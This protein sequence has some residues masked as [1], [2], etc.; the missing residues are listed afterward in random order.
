MLSVQSWGFH[1]AIL[2]GTVSTTDGSSFRVYHSPVRR[3]KTRHYTTLLPRTSNT[4]TGTIRCCWARRPQ[5]RLNVTRRVSLVTARSR[6]ARWRGEIAL[7][8][9][10]RTTPDSG[11]MQVRLRPTGQKAPASEHGRTGQ[12]RRSTYE[13]RRSSA[14]MVHCSGSKTKLCL[15]RKFATADGDKRT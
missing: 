9:R 10:R 8:G 12:S 4:N 1:T 13:S 11:N 5:R 3:Y 7:P 15:L 14:T 2:R 6:L